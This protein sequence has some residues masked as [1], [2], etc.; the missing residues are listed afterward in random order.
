MSA[1]TSMSTNDSIEQPPP[2]HS[3][4][5]RG[6]THDGMVPRNRRGVLA[7]TTLSLVSVLLLLTVSTSKLGPSDTSNDVR[8]HASLTDRVGQDNHQ[9]TAS[10]ETPTPEPTTP[11]SSDPLYHPTSV[12][13]DKLLTTPTRESPSPSPTTLAT[14]TPT[15]MPTPTLVPHLHVGADQPSLLNPLT[16]SPSIRSHHENFD[17]SVTRDRGIILALHNGVIP[18]GL[19]LIKDLR[20]LGNQELIQVYHCF[21]NELSPASRDLL[22]L[23]ETRLE[24]I[25]VCTDYINRGLL[26][27]D[28]ATKFRSWW[29]KPLALIHTDLKEAILMD[30]DAIPMRDPAVLRSLPGYQHT[31]TTFFFD[32]VIPATQYLNGDAKGRPGV[33]L[34]QD[35]MQRFDYRAFNLTGP[36]PSHH[37]LQS[38]SYIRKTAHEMDSSMVA[39]DK[40]RAAK[41]MEVLWFLITR[42]RFECEF[43]WG[44]KEAFWLAFELAHVDYFFSPWAASVV[45]SSTNRD[46]EEHPDTLCGSLAHFLP[47]DDETPELFYV[48]GRATIHPFPQSID[49]MRRANKNLLYNMKP[50]H[51][52]PRQRRAPKKPSSSSTFRNFPNECLV[53]MGSTPLPS[54]FGHHLLRRRAF[55]MAIQL[56]VFDALDQC[57]LLG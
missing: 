39:V 25:D 26:T 40:T 12:A 14:T 6:S 42:T 5:R 29:I 7:I 22:L 10:V 38:M 50:T 52:T 4:P 30:A 56:E 23:E 21:P 11:P 18:L 28:L 20:C 34:L 53:E 19:S 43:S 48:N 2:R 27:M 31:G 46:V 51:M 36:S 8:F 13:A 16:S 15:P 54:H 45:S 32:R 35:L 24:I 44:D 49:N 9:A 17:T 57:E 37:L 41:A 3:P 55:F 1:R 33:Q 47:V